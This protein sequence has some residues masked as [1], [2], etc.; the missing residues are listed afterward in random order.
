V[1]FE[2]KNIFFYLKNALV[3]YN[4]DV[5]RVNFEVEGLAPDTIMLGESTSR[6]NSYIKPIVF[7]DFLATVLPSFLTKFPKIKTTTHGK[8]ICMYHIL[9]YKG[10]GLESRF[11]VH[12]KEI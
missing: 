12:A 4:A 2:N 3:Y 1:R 5:V 6:E 8:L 9:A 7:I 10:C 11:I